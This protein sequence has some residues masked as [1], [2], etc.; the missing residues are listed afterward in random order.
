MDSH[1]HVDYVEM[2]EFGLLQESSSADFGSGGGGGGGGDGGGSMRP[3]ALMELEGWGAVSNLDAFF[4]TMCDAH[5]L[6]QHSHSIIAMVPTTPAA[7]GLLAMSGG[8]RG[9]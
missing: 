3:V 4:T 1:R 7:C 2:A 9:E 6:T 5:K 8:R